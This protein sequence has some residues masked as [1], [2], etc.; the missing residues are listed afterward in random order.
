[1]K[2]PEVWEMEG[3]RQLIGP[4]EGTGKENNPNQEW[5]C[6]PLDKAGSD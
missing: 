2:A 3:A 5:N 4:S 6:F 1:M